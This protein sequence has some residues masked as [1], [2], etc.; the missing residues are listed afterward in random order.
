MSLDSHALLDQYEAGITQLR[1]LLAMVP[2]ELR[3]T[4]PARGEW[5][6]RQVMIH[7][8]D[9]EI[10]G[11]A[12]FRQLLAEPEPALLHYDQ[13]AWAARLDYAHASAEEAVALT[14]VLRRSTLTLLKQAAPEDWQRR[15][16][17]KT[18]GWMTLADLTQHYI[19]H[20]N[21]HIAQLENIAAPAGFGD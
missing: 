8:A 3:D 5:T 2:P 16:L 17:H 4:P 15:G 14:I 13:E 11:A 7:L 18:R 9:S 20:L 10:V 6:A 1:G 12:R 19:N 21:A